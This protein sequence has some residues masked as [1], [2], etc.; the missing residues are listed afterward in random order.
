MIS[1][2]LLALRVGLALRT[3][4]RAWLAGL[5]LAFA[6]LACVSSPAFANDIKPTSRVTHNVVVR[7]GPSAAST[8]IGKLHPGETL[9]EIDSLPSWYQVKLADGTIG[10][11]S[12][13]WTEEV[14]SE[15][16]IPSTGLP[17]FH[18]YAID[19]GTG[20]SILVTG[21]DF[22]L[23]YD[24]GSNDDLARGTSNR[25]IAFLHKVRPDLHRLDHVILSHPH[26]DHVELLP[27]V[28][29]Q[30]Q[31]GDV[32]DSGRVNPIC[33]YRLFLQEIAAHPSI[34]YH[35]ALAGGGEDDAPFPAQKCYGQDL[36]AGTVNV[37]QGSQ[38]TMSPVRLGDSA[39][40]T[41]LH[42][43]G[44]DLPSPNQN[45]LVIRLDLGSR[46]I[47]LMG[48]AEAGGRADP[49]EAPKPGSIESDLLICCSAAVKADLMVVGHHGSRTS[50][51]AAFVA[52]VGAHD[53]IVSSGPTKYA[54]VTLP[55]DVIINE[56][57]AL[58]TV[59]RTDKNDSTCPTANKIGPDNDG[60]AGGCDN[61]E[62]D[63]DDAGN[64]S[65]RY[66]QL[67]D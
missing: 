4:T 6:V 7:A 36:P 61:I 41:I 28:I 13:A 34:V 47:L 46:R 8:A 24:G 15:A 40:M 63:I 59:W 32:W 5:G 25:V 23:L 64:V 38:I 27:D 26:R 53:F 29:D 1:I 65:I 52:A 31:V 56:L 44:R 19:V 3:P 35:N 39:T 22:A 20:L 12:K 37:K 43:D 66:L 10:Y 33:G 50:S 42:A 62:A 45:S 17:A 30:Y 67:V 11:V 48:D 57:S 21:K 16:V 14:Q 9:P 51:R 55:D 2:K 49:S 58:G 18:L 60:R 54:S